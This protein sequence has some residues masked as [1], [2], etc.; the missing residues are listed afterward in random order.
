LSCLHPYEHGGDVETDPRRRTPRTDAVL[1]E[2]VVAEAAPTLAS[3]PGHLFDIVPFAG[4]LAPVGSVAAA[5][6]ARLRR[7]TA[8]RSGVF[9]LPDEVKL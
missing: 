5:F 4:V 6:L 9:S 8:G 2:P 1:A 7:T 3:K